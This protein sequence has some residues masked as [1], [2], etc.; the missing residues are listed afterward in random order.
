[1]TAHSAHFPRERGLLCSTSKSRHEEENQSGRSECVPLKCIAA[2]LVGS[3]GGR[4]PVA[5]QSVAGVRCAACSLLDYKGQ[6]RHAARKSIL[7]EGQILR[8]SARRWWH[9]I[10]QLH[11]L[12]GAAAYRSFNCYVAAGSFD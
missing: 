12:A 11:D 10:A 2:V 4:G 7:V 6:H 1:M 5:D 3:Q 8:D 9:R